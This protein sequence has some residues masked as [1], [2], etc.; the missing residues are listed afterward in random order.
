MLPQSEVVISSKG[1]KYSID[2]LSNKIY[3]LSVRYS[4]STEPNKN[5]ITHEIFTKV[6]QALSHQENPNE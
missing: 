1:K 2:F 3:K 4:Q 6:V 5:S